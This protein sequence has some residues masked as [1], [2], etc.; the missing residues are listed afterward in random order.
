M[1]DGST[2]PEDRRRHEDG[3]RLFTVAELYRMAEAGVF[4]P[5]ERVELVDGVIYGIAPLKP[6]HAEAVEELSDALRAAL[7]GRARG[8]TLNPIYL[9]D[10]SEP[11][12][13]V[14]VVA[15]REGGYW[16]RHPGPAEIHL[17]ADMADNPPQGDPRRRLPCY[18]RAGIPEV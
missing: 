7:F 3:Q 18:A 14:A 9:D 11:R 1:V 16:D 5:D 10:L 15:L 8:C 2:A 12:P 4:G 6:R 13:D 17:L